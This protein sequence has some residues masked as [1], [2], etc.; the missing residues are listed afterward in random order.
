[1]TD[2][3]VFNRR[4]TSFQADGT[5]VWLANGAGVTT[6]PSS[7]ERAFTA[8]E[9]LIQGAAVY[10]SGLN[11]YNANAASGIASFHYN[12]IGITSEAASASDQVIVILDDIVSI[13]SDNLYAETSLEVG[14]YYFLAPT[15]G[16]ITKYST[17]SGEVDANGGFGALVNLG[18][19]VS[20]S[21]LSLEIQ[22]IVELFG[23]GNTGPIPAPSQQAFTAGVDLVQGEIVFVSGVYVVPATAISGA[24][25]EEYSP[26][27]ATSESASALSQVNVI[28]DDV[29]TLTGENITDESQLTPGQYYYLSKFSGQVTKFSTASGEVTASG[30]Y[31]ALVNMG[32]A[33]STSAFHLQIQSPSDL[34][35]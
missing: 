8:G 35:S 18:T 24:S 12:P 11:V 3:A 30:G 2:R 32:L 26:V 34:Y 5:Q 16:Q 15:P 9:D 31:G 10:V 29:V 14:E 33:F 19:A 27:G 4:Y 25:L 20:S 1:V 7:S 13:S 21:E 28:F 23:P 17:A 6:S 22:P